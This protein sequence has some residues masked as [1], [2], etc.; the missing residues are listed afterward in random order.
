MDTAPNLPDFTIKE[1]LLKTSTTCIWRAHQHHLDRP[2]LLLSP[3]PSAQH[4][5]EFRQNLLEVLRKL[6]HIKSP[7]FPEL[8]DIIRHEQSFTLVLEDSNC[9]N[10]LTFLKQKPLA[11]SRLF[12]LAVKLIEGLKPLQDGALLCAHLSPTHLFIT[13][14]GA[15][16]LPDLTSLC[17]LSEHHTTRYTPDL[18]VWTAPEWTSSDTTPIDIR[19]TFFTLGMT[20]YALATAQIPF[21]AFEGITLQSARVTHQLPS[22]CDLMHDFPVALEIILTRMTLLS[23]AYR[24]A[25]CDELL[26]DLQQAQLGIRPTL[27]VA[28]GALIAPS[29]QDK[30]HRVPLSIRDM[31]LYKT[32]H[33]AA[34]KWTLK[35]ILLLEGILFFVFLTLFILWNL[36]L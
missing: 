36:A 30:A 28:T 12:Y 1:V 29:Y 6:T 9:A 33:T 26:N 23:P 22:P 19:A 15:P 27:P 3:T 17:P 7:L 2:V 11:P 13:E 24:Y 16:F 31:R 4:D 8:L 35:R 10:I 14:D 5:A 18:T 21:G 20:L 34:S 25:T 32:S